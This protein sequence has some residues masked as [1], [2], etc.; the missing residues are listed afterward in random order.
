MQ[1]I[2]ASGLQPYQAVYKTELKG[3]DVNIKRRVQIKD[4]LVIVRV[5]AKR[6][7]FGVHETSTLIDQG[8]GR[9][10]SSSYK[11]KRKGLSHKHDKELLFDW[12]DKMVVDLLKPEREP[13]PVDEPSYDKLGYQLQMRLDLIRNPDLQ[14]LEY[15]VT[16]GVRN[17]TYTF[18]FLD[19]EILETPLGK[20]RTRKFNRTGDD[21]D[22]QVVVWVAPD[23]DFLLVRI[24]QT[25]ETGGKTERMIL[26]SAKIAGKEVA[27]L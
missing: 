21:D 10:S 12:T 6:L 13:L 3:F 11:H 22:R 5:D 4:S 16:N 26:K 27:G 1:N 7:M 25:K 23:W 20:I 24:D 8:D 18:N 15:A 19:E 9:L 17:R 2:F 14:H